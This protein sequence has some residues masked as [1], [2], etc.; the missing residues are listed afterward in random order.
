M[1]ELDIKT[2]KKETKALFVKN[3]HNKPNKQNSYNKIN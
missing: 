3:K 2:E 1:K